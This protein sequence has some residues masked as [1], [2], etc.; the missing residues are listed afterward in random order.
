[1]LSVAWI[2]G[3]KKKKDKI[4]KYHKKNKTKKLKLQ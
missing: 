4:K 3:W 1:M 2:S